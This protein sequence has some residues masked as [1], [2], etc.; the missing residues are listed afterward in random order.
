MSK[1]QVTIRIE[2]LRWA[3]RKA[4]L[5]QA[6]LA[7]KATEI[8]QAEDPDAALSESLVALIETGRRQP[9]RR[10]VEAILDAIRSVPCMAELPLEAIC[11]IEPGVVAA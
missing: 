1:G 11:D 5:S 2:A 6:A 4:K 9:S 3:R 7:A 10:N 8:L